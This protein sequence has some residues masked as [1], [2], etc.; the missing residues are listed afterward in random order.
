MLC[1]DILKIKI[2]LFMDQLKSMPNIKL[3]EKS[4]LKLKIRDL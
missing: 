2:K 1:E 3:K 4:C